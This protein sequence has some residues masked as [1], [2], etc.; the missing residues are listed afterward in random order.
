MSNKFESSLRATVVSNLEGLR[1]PV[2]GTGVMEY[3]DEDE[4][5][6]RGP[7]NA[8]STRNEKKDRWDIPVR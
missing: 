8:Q 6:P 7:E 5:D 3:S 2:P 1:G 4:D